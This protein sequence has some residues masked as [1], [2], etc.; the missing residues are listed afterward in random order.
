MFEEAGQRLDTGLQRGVLWF[1]LA[2]EAGHH[3]H[4]RVQSVFVNQ[5]TTISDESQHAIQTSCLEHGTRFSS[6]DQL[7]HLTKGHKDC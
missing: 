4:S 1:H 7:Q 5:V 6:T 2:A 3:S